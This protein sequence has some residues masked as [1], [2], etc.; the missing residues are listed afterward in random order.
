M[1]LVYGETPAVA[2]QVHLAVGRSPAAG[3]DLDYLVCTSND[4]VRRAADEGLAD[5][6]VLDGEAWPAGGLGIARELKNSRT[7]CPPIIVLIERPD[8]A[9]L[10]A[11]SQADVVLSHPLDADALTRAVVALLSGSPAAATKEHA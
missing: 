3:I 5:L 7:D 10:G 4:E 11:W 8:D 2:D 6:L 9:W 1:I